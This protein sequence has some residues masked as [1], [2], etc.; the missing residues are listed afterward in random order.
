MR[1]IIYFPD[2]QEAGE[3]DDVFMSPSKGSVEVWGY[4]YREEPPLL[5]RLYH[6]PVVTE[7]RMAEPSPA[8][9]SRAEGPLLEATP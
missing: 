1:V 4:R 3:A 5:L 2:G 7:Q 6:I 8:G 9:G